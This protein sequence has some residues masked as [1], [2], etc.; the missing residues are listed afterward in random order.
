MSNAGEKP[1]PQK[2]YWAGL[3]S[4]LVANTSSSRTKQRTRLGIR[5]NPALSWLTI[6]R[7]TTQIRWAFPQRASIVSTVSLR[8]RLPGNFRLVTAVLT[9]PCWGA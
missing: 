8:Q 5:R 9:L 4:A 2:N 3:R 7:F 1:R 6:P